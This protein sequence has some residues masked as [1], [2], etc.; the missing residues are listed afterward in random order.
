M[1]NLEVC[2]NAGPPATIE[3]LTKFLLIAP[4]KAAALRAE[5]R[6]IKKAGLAAEV[7]EQKL[8]EKSE[9]KRS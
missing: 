6:A 4:E 1:N 3:D 2:R 9:A 7:Y 5:I 8:Q